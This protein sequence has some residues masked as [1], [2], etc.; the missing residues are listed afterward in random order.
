MRRRIGRFLWGVA[1]V[2][3]MA[4]VGWSPVLGAEPIRIG[5]V[6][7]MTS[8]FAILGVVQKDAAVQAV[9][10]INAKGGIRGRKVELIVE[11]SANSNTVALAALNKVLDRDPVAILGPIWG[12]QVL[13]MLPVIGKEKVPFLVTSGTRK[14]TQQGVPW[15]FRYFPH[16]GITKAAYTKFAV[17]E[18]KRRRVGILHV[19]NEYGMSGR[20]VILKTLKK[21]GIKPVAIESH[22]AT[23]K[24]MTAQL[25][26]LKKAGADVI[27]SQAHVQ[28]TALIIK[29]QRQ[30]GIDIPHVASSAASLPVMRK[31]VGNKLIAGIYVETAALPQADP[32]PKVQAWGKEYKRRFKKTGDAFALLYYDMTRMLLEAIR[33]AGT[34]RNAIRDWLRKNRFRGLATTYVCDPEGNCNHKA[35]ILRHDEKG[36]RIVKTYD[37]T[38]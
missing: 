38:P 13:A 25:L 32:D 36:A 37:F 10:E 28:D 19:A 1:S 8:P 15:I 30:L 27:L 20:D 33:Q 34:D 24:D 26:R 23:D 35:V 5:L 2:A 12:T 14:I 21:L 22:N 3:V 17:E 11:D 9:D 16:D 6:H 4:A 7:S 29:Q 31:L 18:L